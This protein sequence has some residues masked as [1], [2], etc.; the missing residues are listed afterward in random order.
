M[1]LFMGR[2]VENRCVELLYILVIFIKFM[3]KF[4]FD[5]FVYKIGFNYYFKRG[6]WRFFF[7]VKF[8]G[9]NI[10]KYMIV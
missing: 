9:K 3:N 8:F 10:I 4:Y 5:I 1:G 6:F 2:V 7:N